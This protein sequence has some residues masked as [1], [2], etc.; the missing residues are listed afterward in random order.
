M[1]EALLEILCEIVLQGIFEALAELGL[2][3]LV[4]SFSKPPNAWLSAI[5]YVLFG[6]AA[7][8][9]S[10]LLFPSHLVKGESLR[11]VNLLVTPIAVGLLMCVVGAWRLRRG[12]SQLR[13][14]R[15]AYGYLFALSLAGVRF[16]FAQ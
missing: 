11:M 7:G 9:A 10:L 1:L 4:G 6:A 12:Q 2:R 8:A 3:S 14:D 5:G 16:T 15:F 13:I